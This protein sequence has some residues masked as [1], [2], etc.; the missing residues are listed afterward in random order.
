MF[1]NGSTEIVRSWKTAKE[2]LKNAS[3]S[4]CRSFF[5]DDEALSFAEKV[6]LRTVCPPPEAM[7]VYVNASRKKV[8]VIHKE[9]VLFTREMSPETTT[10]PRAHLYSALLAIDQI[11]VRPLVI[12]SPSEIV[13]RALIGGVAT[14]ECNEDLFVALEKN[15]DDGVY[16]DTSLDFKSVPEGRLTMAALRDL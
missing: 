13:R 11:T 4:W 5:S 14:P 15:S 8:V 2:R 6:R 12:H 9:T 16:V 1:G 10:L 3:R 7:H